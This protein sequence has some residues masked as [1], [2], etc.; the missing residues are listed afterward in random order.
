[1][2]RDLLDIYVKRIRARV[3]QGDGPTEPALSAE[4]LEDA[5][6]AL[7][8]EVE[9]LTRER[10]EARDWAKDWH[11]LVETTTV[12]LGLPA[13]MGGAEYGAAI[14]KFAAE[15][16]TLTARTREVLTPFAARKVP[17]DLAADDERVS[18]PIPAGAYRAANTLYNSIKEKDNG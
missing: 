6:L 17:Y 10:D 14:Q 7:A 15:L 13:G 18:L 5:V 16:T 8:D 9:R 11:R 2:H 4:N 3:S 12:I 1:M